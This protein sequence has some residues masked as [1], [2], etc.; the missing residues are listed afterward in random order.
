MPGEGEAIPDA[1]TKAPDGKRKMPGE[2]EAMPDAVTKAP[3]GKEDAGRRRSNARR[4]DESTRWQKHLAMV[5]AI[6]ASA[7]QRTNAE[8]RQKPTIISNSSVSHP[9]R[10]IRK[11][12]DDFHVLPV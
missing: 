10:G 8:R 9:Q 7:C 4:S 6:N 12:A 11:V 2:G 1:V 3:G 5:K